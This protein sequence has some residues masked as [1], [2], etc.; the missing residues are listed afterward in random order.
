MPFGLINP[1][2]ISLLE[3]LRNR[4]DKEAWQRFVEIYTPLLYAF[5]RKLALDSDQAADLVHEVFVVLLEQLP[6][7]VYDPQQRFRGW[8]WTVFINK[9][10]A[11]QRVVGKYGTLHDYPQSDQIAIWIEAD[12]HRFV[13]SRVVDVL[14]SDFEEATWKAFWEVVFENRSPEAVARELGLS[15]ASV[16][17]AKSRVLRR[18]RQ[19]LKGLVDWE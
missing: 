3:R 15:V 18:L 1:T 13:I 14:R 17:Q 7:F 6:Q 19:E 9:Y 10:R 8:L 2:P 11:G 5:A 12:Y 16:Y 4:G